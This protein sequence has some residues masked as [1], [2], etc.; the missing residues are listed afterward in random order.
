MVGTVFFSTSTQAMQAIKALEEQGIQVGK[1]RKVANI[2][3]GLG[4]GYALDLQNGSLED[5]L[6]LL[7]TADIRYLAYQE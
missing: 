3:Q 6:Q 2:G 1:V 7:Q 4:C 5:A